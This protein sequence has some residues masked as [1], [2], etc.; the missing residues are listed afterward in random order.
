M[1]RH[2]HNVVSLGVLYKF[3]NFNSTIVICLKLGF[4]EMLEKLIT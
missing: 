2:I 4:V 3:V 1:W